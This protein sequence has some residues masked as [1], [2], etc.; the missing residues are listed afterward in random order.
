MKTVLIIV[1][2]LIGLGV[3]IGLTIRSIGRKLSQYRHPDDK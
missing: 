3:V 1:G 2:I